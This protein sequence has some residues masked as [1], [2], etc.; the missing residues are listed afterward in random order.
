MGARRESSRR[1]SCDAC[2]SLTDTRWCC[3]Y[4]CVQ[5]VIES[6]PQCFLQSYIYCVVIYHTRAGIASTSELAMLD[7]ASV[8]PTCA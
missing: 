8:L 4:G 1:I 5:V 7:F 6:L 2:V 3:A